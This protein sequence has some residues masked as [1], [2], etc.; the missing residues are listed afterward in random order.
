MADAGHARHLVGRVGTTD[1]YKPEAVPP[2]KH[3]HGHLKLLVVCFVCCLFYPIATVFQ[4]YL[5]SDIMYEM[6]W[7]KPGPTLL[8]TEVIF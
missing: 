8:L 6:R 5:G 4:L 7:R 3:G 2:T 1:A